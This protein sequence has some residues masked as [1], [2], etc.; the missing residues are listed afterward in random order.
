MSKPVIQFDNVSKRFVLHHDKARSVQDLLVKKLGRRN[1]DLTNEEFWALH[2]VSFQV[3]PGETVG[4]IGPNG[5]GK[6]TALKLIARIFR[7][8]KGK[9]SVDGRLNALIE[10]GVG[11]HPE[12]TGREN[13]YL[14]GAL[15]GLSRR[16]IQ[17]HFDEIVAFSELEKFMDMQVKHYS[18]GMHVRLGFAIATCIEADILLVDEVLAVGDARFQRKCF[19]RIDEMRAR[20]TTI[21]FVS[22]AV[23]EVE[24]TCTRAL[25]LMDGRLMADG[26]PAQVIAQYEELRKERQPVELGFY[27]VEYSD[28]SVPAEMSLEGRYQ[29]TVTLRNQSPELW[30]NQG[31]SAVM[32]S[33]H[34]LDRW[35]SLHQLLGPGTPLPHALAP[36][37]AVTLQSGVMPP[38][39]PGQYRLEI[40][41]MRDGHGWF[42][43]HGCPGP[44]IPV[45]VIDAKTFP[46]MEFARVSS[47][48]TSQTAEK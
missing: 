3:L 41:L 25:L 33:Y 48:P 1:G 10:V 5:A 46:R 15:L 40:D 47:H 2:E 27:N 17:M 44:Q 19:E 16:D 22:H 34:W 9:I 8:T 30:H 32:L 20:G 43:R 45:Q 38:T 12:L 18:S 39:A 42:S 26:Q 13:I 4:L 6:S 37:E 23:A 28:Y 11:F 24:R 14:T 29:M 7:P 21:F 35:G 31:P 36:G